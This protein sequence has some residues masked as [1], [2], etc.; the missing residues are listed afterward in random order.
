MAE[1]PFAVID[2]TGWDWRYHEPMGKPDKRWLIHPE[3]GKL[4]LWKPVTT[5][6]EQARTFL[7]GEDWAEKI[8]AEL[9]SALG[10]PAARAELAA[11]EGQPGVIVAT[12]VPQGA[13]LVH[14]NEVLSG[15]IAGYPKERRQEVPQ[16]TVASVAAALDQSRVV[17]SEGVPVGSAL[18]VFVLYLAL[19]VLIANGDRH[20]TNWGVLRTSDGTMTLC[21]SFDH[22]SSLGFQLSDDARLRHLQAVD[23]IATYAGRARSRPFEGRPALTDLLRVGLAEAPSARS[24]IADGLSTMAKAEL[25]A[26]VDRVPHS[27][28]S[29]PCRTF[30]N[31]LLLT[32]RARILDVCSDHGN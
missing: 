29:Q 4:W 6:R 30:V 3:T 26:L 2:V 28:M 25:Q 13:S 17:A 27:R 19:D 1:P 18:G 7:K 5:Q 16:Y 31:E 9:A 12:V 23:G 21:P 8:A 32:N 15:V 20:H 10:I 14:G 22:A 24:V 11:R